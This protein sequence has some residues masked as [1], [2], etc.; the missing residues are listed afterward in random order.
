MIMLSVSIALA[1]SSVER[2][3]RPLL[4]SQGFEW[5]LEKADAEI[6]YIGDIQQGRRTY[7]I[8]LYNAVNR[9]SLHGINRFII[10]LNKTIYLGVYDSGSAHDCRVE[11]QAVVCEVDYPGRRIQFTRNGPPLRLWL[12]G[13][14]MTFWLA[15]RFKRPR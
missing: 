12:D 5:T 4:H 1:L 14:I 3:I 7:R 13:D 6:E 2:D 8:Y 11:K 10:F 9:E 15:P